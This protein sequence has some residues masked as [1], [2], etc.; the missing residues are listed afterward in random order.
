[1]TSYDGLSVS[2]KILDEGLEI[3]LAEEW[4]EERVARSE[5]ENVEGVVMMDHVLTQSECESIIRAAWE[6]EKESAHPVMW[7]KWAEDPEAEEKKLGR[8]TIFKSPSAAAVVFNR[9]KSLLPQTVTTTNGD[10]THTWTLSGLSERLKFLKYETSQA[11]PGHYDGAYVKSASLQSHISILLYLNECGEA[12][13]GGELQFMA[14]ESNFADPED[15]EVIDSI[16]PREGLLVF[17]PHRRLHN[18]APV[19][20]GVKHAVRTDAMYTLT[21]TDPPTPDQ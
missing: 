16:A 21:H 19:S 9:I 8:R 4:D 2:D 6:E 12:Y 17:F 13:Q 18:T 7:R 11:F 14:R 15:C 1:M 20:S 5:L 3:E 10:G